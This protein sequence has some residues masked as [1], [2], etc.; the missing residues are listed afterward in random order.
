[1]D[2]PPHLFFRSR[3]ILR[4]NFQLKRLKSRTLIRRFVALAL[5]FYLCRRMNFGSEPLARAE[6]WFL[7]LN[8]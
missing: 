8:V 1:M 5:K 7:F 6:W 2:P 3:H 4:N